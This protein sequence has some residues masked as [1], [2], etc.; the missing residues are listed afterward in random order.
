MARNI[1]EALNGTAKALARG[2]EIPA[3]S[4][5]LIAKPILPVWFYRVVSNRGWRKQLKKNKAGVEIG[6]HAY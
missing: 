5:R 2:E 4:M 3:E 1:R 6:H